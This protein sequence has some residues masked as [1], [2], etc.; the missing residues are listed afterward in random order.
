MFKWIT[1]WFNGVRQIIKKVKA[2]INKYMWMYDIVKTIV[3][4]I[5]DHN[6][7][8]KEEKYVVAFETITNHLIVEGYLPKTRVIN[9]MIEIAVMI[10]EEYGN[11]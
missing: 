5:E 2:F 9:L 10:M 11:E 3:V 6:I 8:T 7:I 1:N 4:A